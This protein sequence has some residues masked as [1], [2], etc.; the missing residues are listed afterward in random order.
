ML[1]HATQLGGSVVPRERNVVGDRL[2]T[3]VAAP[4]NSSR[5]PGAAVAAATAATAVSALRPKRRRDRRDR[6]WR[7]SVATTNETNAS[8]TSSASAS[9]FSTK[10]PTMKD[11][12][13][14]QEKEG[15]FTV[16]VDGNW[17]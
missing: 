4:P 5:G 2:A 10:E 3:P 14:E 7:R 13:D 16:K 1:P 8:V 6:A 17:S 15:E 12:Y 9:R 11:W